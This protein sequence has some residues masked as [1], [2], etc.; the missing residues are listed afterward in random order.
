MK[1]QF[2]PI[3]Q[4]LEWFAIS[5]GESG[6]Q[7]GMP[8][9]QSLKRPLQG[10]DIQLRSNTRGAYNVVTCALRR[11]L[12]QK[13]QRLLARR[14]RIYIAIPVGP[15]ADGVSHL[16]RCS[17]LFHRPGGELADARA[18]EDARH[19]QGNAQ[20]R[21]DI[22]GQ[23]DGKKRVHPELIDRSVDFYLRW[24]YPRSRRNLRDKPGF[25]S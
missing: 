10:S 15:Q 1:A 21:L 5:S 19:W 17:H 20:I 25:K 8:L 18:F 13:P 9:D 22:V 24:V 2:H 12:V 3:V 7:A 4:L 23:L 11:K 16:R 6:S 14:E